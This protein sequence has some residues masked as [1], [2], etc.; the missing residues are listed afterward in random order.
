MKIG[1]ISAT[2][3]FFLRRIAA[4]NCRPFACALGFLWFVQSIALGQ[5]ATSNLGAISPP[6]NSISPTGCMACMVGELREFSAIVQARLIAAPDSSPVDGSTWDI[7]GAWGVV[8]FQLEEINST[9]EP[10]WVQTKSGMAISERD[11][12]ARVQFESLKANQQ[13]LCRIQYGRDETDLQNGPTLRFRTLAGRASDPSVRFVVVTGMNYAKFHG[14][15]RIDREQHRVENNIDLP[16][17]YE[18][19]D[20]MLGYPALSSIVDAQ[21]NFFIGTGD[22]VY[23]DTPDKFR[24]K[25]LTEMRQKWHEQ[26]A[27]TLYQELFAS[28]PTYWMVDDHDYRVDDCDNSGMYEPLPE[29]ARNVVLEQLPYA[30]FEEPAART[31]RTVRVSKS[32]QIWLVENRMYRSPNA[33]PDGPKKSIWGEEQSRWLRRTLLESDAPYKLLI[34]PTPMVGPD[35]LRKTDNH[36]DVNGFQ[37]ERDAFFEWLSKHDLIGNGFYIVCGD[38]H[39]QYHA[40]DPSG[41]E[42]FSCGALVDAN[43]RLAR[44]PGDPKGTDPDGTIR[45]LHVQTEPSGG[46]LVITCSKRDSDQKAVLNFAFADELGKTLYEHTASPVAQ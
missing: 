29:T 39:W 22:N 2:N 5:P 34:S 24:A 1:Y 12:I 31:Y 33:M 30:P 26:F 19:A 28:V 27:Q 45:H 46:F 4:T 36:C 37:W 14:D 3:L 8:Q 38:R 13:Y 25:S 42:E 41:V 15:Q 44:M 17:S 9:S 11:F 7:P 32:L 6:E 10:S 16:P 23:Y 18:G 40:V 20:R 43:A 21:P 35:D